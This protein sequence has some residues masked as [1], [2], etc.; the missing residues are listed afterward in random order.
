MSF[1]WVFLS[2]KPEASFCMCCVHDKQVFTI[3]GFQRW[4]PYKNWMRLIAFRAQLSFPLW[5]EYQLTSLLFMFLFLWGAPCWVFVDP[6]ISPNWVVTALTDWI[7]DGIIGWSVFKP[8]WKWNQCRR[9]LRHVSLRY[10]LVKTV[11]CTHCDPATKSSRGCAT[12]TKW[13]IAR[14]QSF[15]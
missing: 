13:L 4:I 2:R 7:V 9:T 10:P 14:F 1:E 3:G 11:S 6:V 12:H 5:G 8:R 15:S